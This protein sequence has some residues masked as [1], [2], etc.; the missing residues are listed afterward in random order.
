M[1]K[2]LLVSIVLFVV[3]LGGIAYFYLD[4]LV[5]TGI[6]VVGSQVLGT[7]ISNP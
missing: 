7:G 3:V 2:K 1:I 4:G 6:Q 5:T